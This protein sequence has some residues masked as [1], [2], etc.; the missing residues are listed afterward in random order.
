MTTADVRAFPP[1]AELT[2]DHETILALAWKLAE[3]PR[4]GAGNERTVRDELLAILDGHVAKE[5]TGLYP[6]LVAAG[7]LSVEDS[8]TLEDEHRTLRAARR[9]R[10]VRSSRL[11]RARGAHRTGGDGALPRRHVRI[12]RR[13]MG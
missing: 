12:R 7:D 8:G 3:S 5:E 11:L 1:I 9:E 13:R 10:H 2:A 6:L 4:R